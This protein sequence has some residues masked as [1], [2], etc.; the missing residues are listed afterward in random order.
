M[1]Q[2][3]RLGGDPIGFDLAVGVDFDRFAADRLPGIDANAAAHAGQHMHAI[4]DPMGDHRID[5]FGRFGERNL[6]L[7]GIAETGLM[8]FGFQYNKKPIGQDIAETGG[9]PN[10]YDH[11][12]PR[13]DC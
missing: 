13:A 8:P 2:I 11:Y 3:G 5:L 10:G 12:Y 6:K 7:P 1:R 4:D 9:S